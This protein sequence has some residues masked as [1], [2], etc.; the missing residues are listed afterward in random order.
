MIVSGFPS[1]VIICARAPVGRDTGGQ[2]EK[3][4]DRQG[5][6]REGGRR[7]WSQARGPKSS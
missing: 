6:G 1:K 2:S 3:E 5:G 7:A 4:R